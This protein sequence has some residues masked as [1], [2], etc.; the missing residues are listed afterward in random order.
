MNP[1]NIIKE[2]I[3]SN[4]DFVKTH[5][6]DYFR[7]HMVSQ[8]PFITL[9]S[10]SDSGVQPGAL[11]KDTIN[12]IFEINNIGNQILTSE[13]SVDYGVYHLHTPYL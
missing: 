7:P 1:G 2:I 8:S 11:L 9:V 4:N 3:N 10:C 13:G 5:D 6:E 12:R